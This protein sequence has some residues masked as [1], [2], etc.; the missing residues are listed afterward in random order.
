M[1]GWLEGLAVPG[2]AA[3]LVGA[4]SSLHCTL[5]CGPLACAGSPVGSTGRGRAMAGW[6]AGRVLAYAAV[7]LGLGWVGGRAAQR[8]SHTLQPLLPWVMALGLVATAFELGKRLGAVPGVASVAS[9]LMRGAGRFGST[10]RAVL[11][12]AATP[13]LPCGLLYG[14]FATAAGAGSALGGAAMVG[15]FALGSAPALF[16]VQ[17]G[18]K[19]LSRWPRASLVV[20]RAV[21]LAAAAVLVWRALNAP[22]EGPP[23]CGDPATQPMR[24]P[25]LSVGAVSSP[26]GRAR[27]PASERPDA[28]SIRPVMRASGQALSALQPLL[29]SAA[30]FRRP[31]HAAELARQL[32]TLAALRHAFPS[33]GSDPR[34]AIAAVLGAAL[35]RAEVDL[36]AGR[37]EPARHRL[38]SVITV[39]ASCHARQLSARDA[40]IVELAPELDPL[41]RAELLVATRRFD[42][43][44]EVWRSVLANPGTP[45][46]DRQRALE[47]ALAVT[48]Q[49]KDDPVS[50]GALLD[51]ELRRGDLE[52]AAT[53]ELLR[54]RRDVDG[55]AAE[56]VEVR[57]LPPV[58]KYRRAAALVA[59]SGALATPAPV[60]AERITLLRATTSLWAALQEAPGAAWNGEALYL[61]GV[62]SVASSEPALWGL[63]GVYLEACVRGW[64]HTALARKCL[65]RARA[66]TEFDFSGSGGLQVPVDVTAWVAQLEVLAR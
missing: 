14:L 63:D 25:S 38:R 44:L 4:S 66:R 62:A 15:G 3:V 35:E 65:E 51:T 52:P 9:A 28:S 10:G 33:K 1:D 47:G 29:V 5:M 41:Q 56:R 27:R 36:R 61:L 12:G 59:T 40:D 30:E 8:F 39:C 49:V 37:F 26:T 46:Y 43:A 7:G 31:E 54:Q 60:E 64:P 50:T 23:V 48:V 55:W 2:I 32:D 57:R 34:A 19:P 24:L 13:F 11:L 17:L 45:P 21:P 53:A 42:A 22:A 18:L 6:H 16:G 58:T 20:R